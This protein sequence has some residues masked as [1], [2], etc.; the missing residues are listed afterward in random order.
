M[1][2]SVKLLNVLNCN[3]LFFPRKVQNNSIYLFS[4]NRFYN[5][6]VFITFEKIQCILA[7]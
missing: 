7:E 5:T 1:L 3:W 6:N 2:N 4:W